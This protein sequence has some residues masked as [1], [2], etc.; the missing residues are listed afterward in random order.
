MA[1]DLNNIKHE[2]TQAMITNNLEEANANGSSKEN[3]FK[4]ALLY[5]YMYCEIGEQHADAISDFHEV[6]NGVNQ[7]PSNAEKDMDLFN[8][9]RGKDI[10]KQNGC[11][12]NVL[13][14]AVWQAYL[15]Q[16][17][18]DINGNGTSL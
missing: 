12:R 4:H 15:N 7:N 13:L 1:Y 11:D 14:L 2:V 5:A 8:N 17:L 3:A 6:C 18:H 16:V 10:V 9:A